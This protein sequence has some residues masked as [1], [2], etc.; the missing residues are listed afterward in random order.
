MRGSPD[1]ADD[2]RQGVAA[3][4]AALV[5]DLRRGNQ[6][7]DTA[8]SKLIDSA[9]RNVPGAQYVGITLARHQQGVHTI[10]ATHRYPAVLD[11][12]HNQH[13]EGP[14]LTAAWE[15]RMVRINDLT[16]DNR[17]PRYR[18]EVIDRTPIRSVLAFELFTDSDAA[19]TLNFYSENTHAFRQESVE[20]GLIFATNIALAWVM[21]RRYEQFRSALASRDLIG[22]AEGVIMER[23]HVGAMQA[24]ELLKDLSQQSN[25]KL[26][27]VAQLI[28]DAE[29]S[30][31]PPLP[32]R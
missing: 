27:E 13:Q 20:L 32:R 18:R 11:E 3:Q 14:C 8:L 31:G 2:S 17:W 21:L 23:H 1:T 9:G 19:G 5:G 4:L 24:F 10:V 30:E 29:F 12:I 22:H 16:V 28:I 6:G 7:L 15:H 25:I 26:V